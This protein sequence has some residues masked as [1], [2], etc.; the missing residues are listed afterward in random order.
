MSDPKPRR[1]G[2]GE[3][4]AMLADGGE[5]ALL[6]VREELIFSRG[7][8]LH[9]RS[10]PLSRLELR[11]RSLVP[12]TATR[13]VLV[14]DGDGLARRAA[15]TLAR[16]GYSD[17]AFLDGGIAA[18]TAAGCELF[19]GINVPSKA[20]GEFVEHADATPNIGAEELEKLLRERA[21]VVVLDSRPFDEYSRM[22]IPTGI[23]VP[24]AE[25]V[26]RARDLAPSPDTTIVVNCAGRTRSIIGAQSLINAGVPNKVVALRN[27]TMG[28]NLAGFTCDSGQTR[29]APNPSPDA[30]AWARSAAAGVAERFGVRRIE[31]ADVERFRTDPDRTLYVFD[32][33]DPEEYVAGHVAGSVSAPG[34]QLVQATDQYVGTLCARIV[35]VDEK[36]V[37]ALMT[38]SWLRQMGFRDV[39]V[40]AQRG[41]ERGSRPEDV[42]G[43]GQR[44]E[45]AIDPAGLADLVGR[46]AA[47]IID[48]SLSRAYRRGHIPGAWFAIRARLAK[49]LT[50]VPRRAWLVLTSEDGRLAELAA[51][52]LAALTY[53]PVR[54]LKGGN[55]AW[56]AAGHPL[57]ADDPNMA[58]E[59]IDVWLRPYER[60]GEVSEAMVEYLTWETD[61]PE[62]IARDGTADF[63]QFRS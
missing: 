46:G 52:E 41:D 42:P 3:I 54:Y 34:G 55:A 2:A 43:L 23:D 48:L 59:P 6:D 27:G 8:L 21:N 5:L 7:H 39:F 49:A 51:P 10:L 9:A 4:K 57:T 36:E 22:S 12:R 40:L 50:V 29:R 25:L 26:L 62:R 38:G 32:V 19:S 44:P 14:D 33:R 47:T 31:S 11:I 18:W 53:L 28:W 30:L 13:V 1:V 20:F 60:A 58:D 17:I 45:L 24:G 56:Q 35:L 63:A 15:G 16:L 61:L 37:R